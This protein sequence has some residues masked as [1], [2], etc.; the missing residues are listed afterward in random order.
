MGNKIIKSAGLL[1]AILLVFDA[2]LF[3]NL[4]AKQGLYILYISILLLLIILTLSFA[5]MG[6]LKKINAGFSHILGKS[7]QKR[8]DSEKLKNEILLMIDGLPEGILVIDK[9]NKVSFINSKAENFLN[10]TRKKIL[11]KSVLEIKELSGAKKIV[12][13]L[14]A[15]FKAAHKEEIKV[16]DNFVLDI[17]VESLNFGKNNRAKLV[18]MQ[19]VTKIKYA[20]EGKDKF[21]SVTAHQLKAPL[22]NARLSLKMLLDEDFGKINKEQRNILEKTYKNNESLIYLIQDLLKDTRNNETDRPDNRG[23][24]D[25]E[26]LTDSVLD[27]YT[28]EIKE[29]KI[30][31]TFKR[32]DKKLPKVFVELEKIKMVIQNLLDNAVK[33]TPPKGKIEISITAGKKDLEFKIKDS[34]IGIPDNQKE[35]IFTRF[36]GSNILS[37]AKT[38]ALMGSSGLGLVIAKDIIDKHHGKIWFES[39]DGSDGTSGSTFFFSLPWVKK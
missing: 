37:G 30:N 9:D 32:A 36:S 23:L 14:L 13:H 12:S 15:N 39:K 10:V 26:D 20:E 22:S 33:Y 21:I 25:L 28:N 27:F 7:E 16:R 5:E 3:I 18:I 34:G 38:G 31:F 24:A 2:L 4:G 19:D 11:N 1:L 8:I 29:K 6:E 17:T 35:K